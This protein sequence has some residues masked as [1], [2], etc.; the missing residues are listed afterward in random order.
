MNTMTFD[1]AKFVDPNIAHSPILISSTNLT[2]KKCVKLANGKYGIYDAGIFANIGDN[3]WNVDGGHIK[4]F[5]A[6]FLLQLQTFYQDLVYKSAH[7]DNFKFRHF[8]GANISGFAWE[9]ERA[10]IPLYFPDGIYIP[11]QNGDIFRHIVRNYKLASE[12]IEI[13]FRCQGRI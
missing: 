13:E 11:D 9:L 2:P 4:I 8:S 5:R 1:V 12:F 3:W 10:L 7:P 6:Q